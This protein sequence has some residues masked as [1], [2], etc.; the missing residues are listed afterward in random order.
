MYCPQSCLSAITNWLGLQKSLGL[1]F[2]LSNPYHTT[3]WRSRKVSGGETTIIL[4]AQARQETKACQKVVNF[5]STYKSV[6]R[7]KP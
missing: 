2:P 4:T 7:I 6:V 3:E 1:T 5:N